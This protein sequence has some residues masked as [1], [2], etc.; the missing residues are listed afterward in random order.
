MNKL[1]LEHMQHS[2]T[3]KVK[4]PAK[5]LREALRHTLR[6]V[7]ANKRLIQFIFTESKYLDAEHLRL[8]LKMDSDH[9]L[10]YWRRMLSEVDKFKHNEMD[11][12]FAASMVEQVTLFLP[13]RGWTVA[14]RSLEENIN[15]SIDFILK[16]LGIST[17]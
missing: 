13:L 4:D 16:G 7:V 1:W 12:S 3:E 5:R 10:C 2:D 15:S 17:E 6:F 8:V 11:L 14:D 9:V